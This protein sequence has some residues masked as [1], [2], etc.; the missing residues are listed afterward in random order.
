MEMMNKLRKEELVAM[1]DYIMAYGGHGGNDLPR[2]NLNMNH[3]LRFWETNK[4]KLCKLFGGKLILEKKISCKKSHFELEDEMRDMIT[5]LDS[6]GHEFYRNFCKWT[7]QFWDD[8]RILYFKVSELMNVTTL[9]SNVYTGA[10]YSLEINGKKLDVNSGCRVS[11]VL[12]KIASMAKISGYEDFRIA[13]SMCLNQKNVT[14]TL[15]LSIHPLDYMTMSDNDC[16][17]SSCMSWKEGGDYRQGTVEM[18]N[19]PFV[20]VGYLKSKDDMYLTEGSYFKWNSKKWRQLYIVEDNVIMGIK[21]YPYDNNDL[22]CFCLN[23]LRDL[24]ETSS[25]FGAF[26]PQMCKIRNEQHTKLAFLDKTVYFS[27]NTGFMYNDVYSEHDAYV[28]VDIPEFVDICY[29]GES[30]CMLCGEEISECYDEIPTD[31]LLCSHCGSFRHCDD[32][33]CHIDDDDYYYVDG[34][35]ICE[36]CYE[37]Y[38]EQC[39]WCEDTHYRDNMRKIY[40][41]YCGEILTYNYIYV[42]EDCA[43]SP[44]FEERIGIM[45][46]DKFSYRYYISIKNL[47]ED[48][49]NLFD[50]DPEEWGEDFEEEEVEND[51]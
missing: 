27:F 5:E 42:C 7:D 40:L 29:S 34:C 2:T 10:S 13:H 28:N 15:C 19:S 35:C 24:T 11:K 47:K 25:E 50:L 49:Y 51:D 8:D 45:R 16:D 3:I 22:G 37:N 18:M 4:E 20:V 1:S 21:Q 39:A 48:G 43:D 17:W 30:E 9:T 44:E 6:K 41:K 12:G 33:G 26:H 32:C 23:W 46:F 31:T 38:T 14:G 36:S